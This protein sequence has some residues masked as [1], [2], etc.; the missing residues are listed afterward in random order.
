MQFLIGAVL[1][2]AVGLVVGISGTSMYY[3][4]Q[5][6]AGYTR[7]PA[8]TSVRHHLAVEPWHGSLNAPIIEAS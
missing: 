1:G 2:V 8:I 3:E 5:I 7:A 6:L 4:Q